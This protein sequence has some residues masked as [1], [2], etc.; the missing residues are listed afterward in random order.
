[1]LD[2]VPHDVEHLGLDG[3]HLARGAAQLEGAGVE[4]E[5]RDGVDH[6]RCPPRDGGCGV[7]LAT[8]GAALPLAGPAGIRLDARRG[9]RGHFQ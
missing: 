8:E 2:E 5:V 1:M 3:D 9:R 7:T 4:L 6:P